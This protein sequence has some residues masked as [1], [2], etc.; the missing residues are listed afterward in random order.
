[1]CGWCTPC[2]IARQVF[3]VSWVYPGVKSRD[4]LDAACASCVFCNL[5]QK[6]LRLNGRVSSVTK[7]QR[8]SGRDLPTRSRQNSRSTMAVTDTL[9]SFFEDRLQTRVWGKYLCTNP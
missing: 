4:R 8:L 6:N 5:L 2:V 3:S 7:S 1:M 9:V